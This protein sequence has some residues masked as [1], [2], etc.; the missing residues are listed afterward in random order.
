M[1]GGGIAEIGSKVV[2]LPTESI[3]KNIFSPHS[4]NSESER[5]VLTFWLLTTS[6]VKVTQESGLKRRPMNSYLTVN[7]LETTSIP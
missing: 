4:L 3:R 2:L 5:T 1:E 7:Q 6:N